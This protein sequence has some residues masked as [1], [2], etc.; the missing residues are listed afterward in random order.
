VKPSKNP[1]ETVYY[2]TKSIEGGSANHQFVVVATK[3][4]DFLMAM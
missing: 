4:T 3:K 2:V 1:S